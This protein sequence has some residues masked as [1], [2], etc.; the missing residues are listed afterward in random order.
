M[1]E[2]RRD[3]YNRGRMDNNMEVSKEM[4]QGTDMEGVWLEKLD[5]IFYYA[6]SEITPW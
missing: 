6:F 4:L 3:G 5:K 1:G 2:G